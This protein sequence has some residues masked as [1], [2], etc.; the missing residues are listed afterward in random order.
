MEFVLLWIKANGRIFLL[1]AT[2]RNINIITSQRVVENL[3]DSSLIMT[4]STYPNLIWYLK[5]QM[6]CSV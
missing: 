2:H 1:Q 4:L 5:E 6:V 3:R